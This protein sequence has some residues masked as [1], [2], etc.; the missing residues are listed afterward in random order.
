[1]TPFLIIVSSMSI[2]QIFV[3][4]KLRKLLLTIIKCWNLLALELNPNLIWFS[5]LY[6]S[7]LLAFVYLIMVTT[8]TFELVFSHFTNLWQLKWPSLSLFDG[9]HYL[10]HDSRSSNHR[11]VEWGFLLIAWC[12]HRVESIGN[13]NDRFSLLSSYK[14]SWLSSF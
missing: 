7:C 10:N 1:M 14:V 4:F 6:L 13:D 11:Y 2:I 3:D 5:E 8:H 9:Y 12:V